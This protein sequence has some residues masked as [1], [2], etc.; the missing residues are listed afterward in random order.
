M[1]STIEGFNVSAIWLSPVLKDVHTGRF[2]SKINYKERNNLVVE[3]PP[4]KL[5]DIQLLVDGDK[6]AHKISVKSSLMDSKSD[7]KKV[8]QLIDK[9]LF[10]KSE[11]RNER[12]FSPCLTDE[13]FVFFIPIYRNEVSVSITDVGGEDRSLSCIRRGIS[14]RF[15]L[16]L[17]HIEAEYGVFFP[18]WNVIDIRL[19]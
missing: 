11:F 8:I 17:S 3:T 7:F 16:L 10:T 19:C 4:L 6:K 5:V 14:C 18:I 9:E 1:H 12:V 15:T 2:V 13:R